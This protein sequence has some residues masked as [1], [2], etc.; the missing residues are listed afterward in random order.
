[1]HMSPHIE[2]SGD[3][4]VA[5]SAAVDVPV[6][7]HRPAD[8]RPTEADPDRDLAVVANAAFLLFNAHQCRGRQCGE[9]A[10]LLVPAED[11]G[12]W[13]TDDRGIAEPGQISGCGVP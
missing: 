9:R 2:W 12:H 7:A 8:A 6:V 13:C 1:M 5:E 11:I 3:L 10:R 4:F